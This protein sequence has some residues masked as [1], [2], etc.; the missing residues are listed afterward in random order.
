MA[1]GP[2]LLQN[3]FQVSSIC[4]TLVILPSALTRHDVTPTNLSGDTSA[5][6]CHDG[7]DTFF[8]SGTNPT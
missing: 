3:V 1:L 8:A 7:G 4:G 6:T 2:D 5:L